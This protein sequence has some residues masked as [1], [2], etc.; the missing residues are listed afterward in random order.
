M[1]FT[2]PLYYKEV[3]LLTEQSIGWL[4]AMNGLLVATI[5][6]VMIY[7]IEGRWSKLNFI[8]LGTFI[9]MLNY[10]VLPFSSSIVWLIAAMVLMT[11]SEMFAMP[12]MSSYM[13]E[14]S[15]N[16]NRGQYSSLYSMSWSV[17]QITSPLLASQLISHYGYNTLWYVLALICFL[18]TIGVR[19]LDKKK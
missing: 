3:H 11:F 2:L 7:K 16:S 6:M 8:S 19:L 4:L 17:A 1:F 18:I 15:N 9:L 10:L 5:E 12:F 14:R 13:M